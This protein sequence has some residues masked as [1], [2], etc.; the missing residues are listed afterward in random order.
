MK[1][2]ETDILVIGAGPAGLAAATACA[3][4]GAE[5]LVIDDNPR[6]GGQIWRQGPGGQPT[7]T[8]EGYF[9]QLAG[10]RRI[11][12]A[13]GTR[14]ILRTA[15]QRYLLEDD[16]SAYEATAGK[17]IIC[18]GARERFIPFPGWTLPGVTGAG[19]LQ[20]LVKSGTD[21]AGQRI[22]IAGSGPLL[23]ACAD[24]ARRHGARV[25]GI[26]EAQRP[27]AMWSF[28]N[29]L[30]RWP[31]KLWQAATLA[32]PR[33]RL[34]SSVIA[35]HGEHRLQRITVEQNGKLRDIPCDRLACGYG[36]IPNTDI[37]RMLGAD[38]GEQGIVVDAYQRT[39]QPNLYAAGECTGIGG[40]ELSLAEGAIAGAHAVGRQNE[41]NGRLAEKRHWQRFAQAV[42]RAFVL[43]ERLK[44]GV[45]AETIICRC[46]DVTYGELWAF[47]NPAAAKMATRC[48][49]GPCQG[50]ICLSSL[51]FLQGWQAVEPRPPLLP[52]RIAS[53]CRPDEA[54]PLPRQ[55]PHPE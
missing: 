7:T 9:R 45:T 5:V 16:A 1:R 27:G 44:K 43:P 55:Y 34:N 36:L 53:L 50:K 4:G 38:V 28:A 20:S 2:I 6:A 10:N 29:G 18:C 22:V 21:I 41:A 35:A 52:A 39:S 42:E 31:G 19:G 11:R 3:R 32:H 24:T 14:L 23:L 30:W 37:A 8:A 54:P 33:Y 48:G 25:A 40:S 13:P 26:F 46:E 12:F 17:V 47:D 15:E 49:M 51:G